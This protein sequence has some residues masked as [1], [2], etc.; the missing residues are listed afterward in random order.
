VSGH[1]LTVEEIP[2]GQYVRELARRYP[3]PVWNEGLAHAYS[4]A[5]DAQFERHAKL[6]NEL[7]ESWRS[8][9][10]R[11]LVRVVGLHRP[12]RKH[13]GLVCCV[14]YEAD[15]KRIAWPCITYQTVEGTK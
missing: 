12:E 6:Y 5:D 1:G 14:C 3:W 4:A 8:K 10:C 15:G 13:S 9:A 11:A 7:C 2:G